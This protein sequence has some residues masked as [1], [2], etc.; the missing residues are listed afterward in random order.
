IRIFLKHRR[1]LLWKGHHYAKCFLATLCLALGAVTF[2]SLDLPPSPVAWTQRWVLRDRGLQVPWSHRSTQPLSRYYVKYPGNYTFLLDEP[3]KCHTLRP[4][5]VLV[6]PVAPGE[7]AAR[8][9][10]RKT[11]GGEHMPEGRSVLVVFM[12]GLPGGAGAQEQQAELLKESEEH[13]DLLQAHGSPPAAPSAAFGMKVDSDLFVNMPN[14]VRMLAAPDTPRQN[15]ITGMVARDWPVERQSSSKW[16]LPVEVYSGPTYP[17]YVFG[18]SYVFSMDL[19]R[20]IVGI[21]RQVRAVYIEDI[22]LGLCLSKLGVAPTDPPSAGLFRSHRPLLYR[23]CEY[24]S[25]I[26]TI[27]LHHSELLN[28]WGDLKGDTHS[29]TMKCVLC[30]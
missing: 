4:F 25:A 22:Y 10:I 13:H 28:I 24:A 18:F 30:I 2:Y 14:L 20:R 12:L 23:R 26:T 7:L 27:L 3:E 5:L 17:P 11:W 21:S 1:T 9:A 8:Q 19:P 15:Y 6:V 29:D 16:F